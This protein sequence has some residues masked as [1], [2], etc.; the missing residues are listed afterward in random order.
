MSRRLSPITV[1]FRTTLG[2]LI[3]LYDVLILLDSTIYNVNCL[4]KPRQNLL[5]GEGEINSPPPYLGPLVRG[6]NNV[7]SKYRGILCSDAKIRELELTTTTME[8]RTSPNKTFNEKNISSLIAVHERYNSRYISFLSS[9]R[10]EREMTKF[11]S[12]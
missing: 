2:R 1:L 8:T 3:T 7:I 4:S 11:C 12:L 10:Q 6:L 5:E 9:A